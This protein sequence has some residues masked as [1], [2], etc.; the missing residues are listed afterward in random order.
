V[1]VARAFDPSAGDFSIAF[2]VK[3]ANLD[4][5]SD[6]GIID[7]LARSEVGYEMG[8]D[9][10]DLLF[11]LL[12]TATDSQLFTSTGAITDTAKF[13]HVAVTVDRSKREVKFYIDGALD[14]TV[15]ITSVTGS[16]SPSHALW[17]GG[18]DNDL[19]KGLDGML[20]EVRFYD[21]VLSGEEISALSRGPL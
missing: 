18:L 4:R 10:N 7:A 21:C 6:D 20:D 5:G 13:H 12:D 3:R 15:A 11:L 2:F 1:T 8:L 19:E 16:V 9:S 14:S 17:L